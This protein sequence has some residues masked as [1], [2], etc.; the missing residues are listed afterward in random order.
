M[1]DLTPTMSTKNTIQLSLKE[2][3]NG[4]RK[5]ILPLIV[6]IF[7][8]GLLY[9]SV[10]LSIQSMF[11]LYNVSLFAIVPGL[12]LIIVMSHYDNYHQIRFRI[13]LIVLVLVIGCLFLF[14]HDVLNGLFLLLNQ[15]SMVVGAQTEMMF[16]PFHLSIETDLYVRALSIFFGIFSLI[17]AYVCSYA[18]KRATQLLIWIFILP[19]FIIQ[20]LLVITPAIYYNFFLFF[21]GILLVNYS[22]ISGSNRY[23]IVGKSKNSIKIFS[24]LIVFLLFML[25]FLFLNMIEPL[26]SYT[27]NAAVLSMK[28]GL[29]NK[30]EEFRYEKEQTNTFTQGNFSEL[31][32]LTLTDT[33]ALKVV[34]SKPTSL[35]LRGYVGST[36][37]SNTWKSLDY[38]AYNDSYALFYW[39]R[40]SQFNALNQLS[41][42]N[43]LTANAAGSEEPISVTIHNVNANSKYLYTPYELQTKPENFGDVKTFDD[44]MIV[45]TSFFGNRLYEY[46]S[47]DNIVKKYPTVANDLYNVTKN[48]Q[49]ENYFKNEGHY[50][51]YIYKNYLHIPKETKFVLQSHVESINHL[52]DE[53]MSYEDMIKNVK[54]TVKDTLTYNTDADPL[55]QSK[56]FMQYLIEESR[57]GYATHYATFATLLFRSYGVPARY[58]E[59]YLITPKD[60]KGVA[61]YEEVA[62]EGK[63]AHAW[64]E[65]YLDEMGWI[66]IEVTPPYYDVMEKTDL[67]N[68]PEGSLNSSIS[69]EDTGNSSTEGALGNVSTNRSQ[70]KKQVKDDEPAPTNTLNKKPK[71]E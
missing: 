39:L 34:M 66:P 64:T 55:P 38:Q 29:I 35:Y 28:Q 33:P 3:E 68:Y 5:T 50:N 37:T 10:L 13:S 48:K 43:N 36:Y 19:L 7:I 71:E 54:S 56:D 57:E 21:A 20:L 45:S 69:H 67:S 12:I 51:E 6:D 18:L 2:M 47:S 70:E 1:K 53:R 30:V 14:N 58:V 49:T 27:K 9:V 4:R 23:N 41:S 8:S 22:F 62:I 46:Q 24:A 26:S 65:I 11:E 15:V 32:E 61:E 44:N 31:G 63:N 59:G 16:K 17:V 60:V 40:K 25:S 52:N 42:V